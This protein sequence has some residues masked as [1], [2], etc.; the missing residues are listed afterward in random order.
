MPAF[1]PDGRAQAV[2]PCLLPLRSSFLFARRFVVGRVLPRLVAVC[3][4]AAAR[5]QRSEIGRERGK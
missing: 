4:T 1:M 2:S 3:V 5:G